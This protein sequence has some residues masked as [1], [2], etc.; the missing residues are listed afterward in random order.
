M[1]YLLVLFLFFFANTEAP[2][3]IILFS[4]Q[5]Q[6]T[7]R[8]NRMMEITSHEAIVVQ[9]LSSTVLRSALKSP[10]IILFDKCPLNPNYVTFNGQ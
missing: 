7:K 5:V 1:C 4:I 6:F 2:V 9:I 8:N 10:I 3:V